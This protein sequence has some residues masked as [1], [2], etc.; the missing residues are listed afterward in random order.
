MANV[1]KPYYVLPDSVIQTHVSIYL[2]PSHRSGEQLSTKGDERLGAGVSHRPGALADYVA[3]AGDGTVWPFYLNSANGA[4]RPTHD[5]PD[6]VNCYLTGTLTGSDPNW[7]YSGWKMNRQFSLVT[8]GLSKTFLVGEKHVFD[9]HDGE[10]LYGDNSYF[11]DDNSGSAVALAGPQFPLASSPKDPNI[12]FDHRK[13][14]FGSHHSGGIVQFLMMDGSVQQINVDI[15]T[16][17]LGYLA[18]IRDGQV[19]SHF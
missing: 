17:V 2:C 10:K 19:I 14:T 12:I 18:N 7:T 8:D 1:E 15:D 5:C 16:K 4:L 11:N 6:T 13:W 3:S 9:G